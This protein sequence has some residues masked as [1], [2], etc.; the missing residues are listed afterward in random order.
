MLENMG[1]T[2]IRPKISNPFPE[3]QKDWVPRDLPYVSIDVNDT[4]GD[5]FDIRI[6]GDNITEVDLSNQF[7]GSFTAY[8]ITPLPELETITWYVEVTDHLG[9]TVTGEYWFETSSI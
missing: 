8:L 1:L 7:S 2:N 3:N 4:E 6:F 5:P 9:R